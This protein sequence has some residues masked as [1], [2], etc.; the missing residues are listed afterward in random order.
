MG[1]TKTIRVKGVVTHDKS[2]VKIRFSTDLVKL[3]NWFLL[4]RTG[5]I[6]HTPLYGAKISLYNP[7]QH[8]HK[9]TSWG[10]KRWKNRR[11]TVTIDISV[12]CHKLSSK[13]Y[14]VHWVNVECPNVW[15]VIKDMGL[16]P[17]FD[18]RQRPH[19]SISNGKY[20]VK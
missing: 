4:K 2:G 19:M 17:N 12:A 18:K 20:F 8:K 3:L 5:M 13:G 15:K 16:K 7:K 10:L 9:P 1:K 6:F 14:W 11:V